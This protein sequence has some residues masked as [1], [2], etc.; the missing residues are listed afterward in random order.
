MA[1]VAYVDDILL[2]AKCVYP[3]CKLWI[4]VTCLHV[5]AYTHT[6]KGARAK[7]LVLHMHHLI[8]GCMLGIS[9][10]VCDRHTVQQV[11]SDLDVRVV[12]KLELVLG[13]CELK[14]FEGPS[15]YPCQ[16][17]LHLQASSAAWRRPLARGV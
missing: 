12:I 16:C 7:H 13:L 1:E 15:L 4:Y 6:N 3:L 8:L 14:G 11:R 10:D 9:F 2:S 5:S 17:L